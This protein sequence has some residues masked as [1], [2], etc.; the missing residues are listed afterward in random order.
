MTCTYVMRSCGITKMPS[1]RVGSCSSLSSTSQ[2]LVTV[3]NTQ[4]CAVEAR[5]SR[6][7]SPR[8]CGR[9]RRRLRDA[10]RVRLGRVLPKP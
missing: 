7:A 6:Q 3:P 1:R 2:P 9:M 10:L 4:Y 5:R 8:A